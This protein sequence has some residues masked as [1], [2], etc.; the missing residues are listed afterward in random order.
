MVV[1]RYTPVKPTR[2]VNDHFPPTLWGIRRKDAALCTR[3]A[4]GEADVDGRR[5]DWLTSLPLQ[6]K[7]FCAILIVSV[8]SPGASV[9]GQDSH[10]SA[11]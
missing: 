1:G 4:A 7:H 2:R 3:S 10:M 9:G 6:I 8:V 11:V 5:A